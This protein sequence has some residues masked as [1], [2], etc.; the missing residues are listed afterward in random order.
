MG[1]SAGQ[2]PAIQPDR[3]IKILTSAKKATKILEAFYFFYTNFQSFTTQ[4]RDRLF[5]I[6]AIW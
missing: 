1:F 5:R 3:N 2:P 6:V 4:E